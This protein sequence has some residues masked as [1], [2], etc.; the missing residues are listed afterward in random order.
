MISSGACC[1][2]EPAYNQHTAV[3]DAFGVVLDVAVTTGQGNEG[4]HVLPQVDAVAVTTGAPVKTVTA[5]QGYAYGGDT[6]RGSRL[7]SARWGE[8]LA[9]EHHRPSRTARAGPAS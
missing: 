9:L 4:D 7:S 5:Y 2:R 6:T 8:R 1:R 3:D